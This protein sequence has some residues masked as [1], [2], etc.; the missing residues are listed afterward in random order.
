MTKIA[1]PIID[2]NGKPTTVHKNPEQG[3][4]TRAQGV[5]KPSTPSVI[6]VMLADGSYVD[7][8]QPLLEGFRGVTFDEYEDR[9][10]VVV[11]WVQKDKSEY[12][13]SLTPC[14]NATGKGATDEDYGYVSCR[15]CANEVSDIHGG[16]IEVGSYV[17]VAD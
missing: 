3:A 2:K 4:S 16:R 12:L 10:L 13:V 1:T 8:P 17:P 9:C 6:E 15:G 5:P 11:G 14:C 7:V